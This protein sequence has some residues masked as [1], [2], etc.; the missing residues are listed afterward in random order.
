MATLIFTLRSLKAAKQ[1]WCFIIVLYLVGGPSLGVLANWL[2]T[3]K[4][5]GEMETLGIVAAL[6]VPMHFAIYGIYRLGL[7]TVRRLQPQTH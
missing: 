6:I 3:N 7:S 1:S 5:F 4:H 2:T